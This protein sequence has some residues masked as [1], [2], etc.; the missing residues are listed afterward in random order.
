MRRGLGA[1]LCA[2]LLLGSARLPAARA[3]EA[4][5]LAVP[6]GEGLALDG[7]LSEPAWAGA[8]RLAAGSVEVPAPPGAPGPTQR[9]TPD[10]RVLETGGALWLG[11]ELAEDPGTGIGLRLLAGPAT[12]QRAAE[13]VAV[14]Y[15]PCELRAV[16]WSV[17][18]A[19]GG[20]RAAVP[21]E[22]AVDVARAGAWSLELRLP[23]AALGLSA[24]DAPVALALAVA[25]RVANL[26]ASVPDALGSGSPAAWPR[27]SPEAG[28]W[29][30][31][32]AG[33]ALEGPQSLQSL[34]AADLADD[35]RMEAWRRF[36]AATQA[37]GAG[38]S[39]AAAWLAP[40]EAALGEVEALRPDLA[41]WLSWVLGDLLARWGETSAAEARWRAAL[42]AVPGQREA[43]F[44]LEV[45]ARGLALAQG[46]SGAAS[47]WARALAAATAPAP[48]GPWQAYAQDGQR[49]GA[50]L[51]WLKQGDFERALE[52]LAPLAQRYPAEALLVLS[53]ERARAGREAELAE[54]GRRR[55]EEARG[56]LPRLRL[57]T[58]QGELLLELFEDDVPQAVRQLVWLAGAGALDGTP[59]AASTPFLGGEGG[60]DPGYAL[61]R[62]PGRRPALRGTLALLG[63]GEGAVGGRLFLATGTALHLEGQLLV[64]GRLVEG[65]EVAA[66]LSAA[67]RIVTARAERLRPGRDYRPLTLAG[68]P[69]PAPA[70]VPGR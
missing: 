56:D 12:L 44:A 17:R 64:A 63:E 36:L 23:L 16:R 10:V 57:S 52:A 2:A 21:V 13:A 68:E 67:D 32:P 29:S 41:P 14:G 65:E 20:T 50:G 26:V 15:A 24:G 1:G 48:A 55:A 38:A 70:A 66:R 37:P 30:R 34:E 46:P 19:R 69:A 40:L 8:L 51:L 9:L 7:R 35:R 54:R 61:A 31:A 27:L 43:A 28:A 18:S 22:G 4:E 11:V 49:L 58:T 59:V 60:R 42:A 3:A 53:H 45:C 6:R 39:P 62:E 5:P 33:A 47:D 25:T